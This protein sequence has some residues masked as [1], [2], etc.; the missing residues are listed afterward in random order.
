LSTVIDSYGESS[1][2]YLIRGPL[3]LRSELCIM[4]LPS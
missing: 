2:V 1:G 4:F 3:K